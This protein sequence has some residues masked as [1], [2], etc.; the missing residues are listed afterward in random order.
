[1]EVPNM[2]NPFQTLSIS[3]NSSRSTIK[4]AF[5]QKIRSSSRYERAICS[6]AYAILCSKDPSRYTRQNDMFFV[7]KQDHFYYVITGNYELFVREISKQKYL[8]NQRD[9]YGRTLLYIATR[10]GFHNICHFLL[11]SGCQTNETQGDGS[12]ALRAAAFYG[13]QS[14]V[15]LLLEYEANPEIRNSFGNNP[16]DEA[17]SR[18]IRDCIL[19]KTDDKINSCLNKLKSDELVKNL[20]VLKYADKI[21]GKKILRNFDNYSQYSKSYLETNW[22][23][24]WHGTKYKHLH[25]IMKYGLHSV[26]TVLSPGHQISPEKGHIGL[27]VKVG[28][29]TNWANAV[30]I[31][32]S[33]FY[34]AD[35]VYSERIFSDSQRWCVIIEIR[36]KPGSFTK[37]KQTLLNQRD[38]LPG[39]PEDI[40]YRVAVNNDDELIL[41]V[42]SNEN[43]VVTA[44]LFVNLTFL[45]NINEYYQ[46]QD[47]F[48]NSEAE[49]ALFQ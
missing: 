29:F 47:L 31:S 4:F 25:S 24:A 32:P 18:E 33:I 30:F 22:T 20:I 8:L 21:I 42:E 17:C 28:S 3:T 43:V 26:G 35:A 6:L 5:K 36:V 44:L 9:E 7:K 23:L 48:A 38:L 46:G 34:A 37:H 45:E 10:S 12:T 2:I 41:R 19:S 16:K 27:N 13:H 15:E 1:M 14:I 40:E 11:R 49:R 39:E